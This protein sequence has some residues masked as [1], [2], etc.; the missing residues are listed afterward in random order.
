MKS[1]IQ[2]FYKATL[3]C[4]VTCMGARCA[5][6]TNH[7]DKQQD[8]QSETHSNE[9]KLQELQSTIV[10][11][12]KEKEDQQWRQVAE[13]FFESNKEF[14]IELYNKCNQKRNE[15]RQADDSYVNNIEEPVKCQ[16]KLVEIL[17]QYFAKWIRQPGS[18]EGFPEEMQEDLLTIF[19]LEMPE[20]DREEVRKKAKK[21]M[22]NKAI[23]RM[24][25]KIQ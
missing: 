1:R 25:K 17:W 4:L 2:Y 18:L 12:F 3:L 14:L 13:K 23:D 22:L 5:V 7:I 9:E 19:P 20:K 24:M 10:E 16:V 11:C 21:T 15:R 6:G 8:A